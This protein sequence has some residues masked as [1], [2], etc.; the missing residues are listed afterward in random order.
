MIRFRSPF[1]RSAQI[2][3]MILSLACSPGC[4]TMGLRSAV[5]MSVQVAPGTPKESLVYIDGNYIGTL[6]AVEAG[7]CVYQ[8][9][10]TV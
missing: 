5:N 8:R 3:L 1:S 6:A 10:N 7:G 4:A 9:E 2:A